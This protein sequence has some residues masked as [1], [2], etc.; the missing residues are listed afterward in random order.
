M[1]TH[2]YWAMD[3]PDAGSVVSCDFEE[4]M[5]SGAEE[6]DDVLLR[7]HDLGCQDSRGQKSEVRAQKLG[8][9]GW[10]GFAIWT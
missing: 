9:Y 5:P 6:V 4:E 10:C 3:V 7:Q 2:A 8:F 1:S